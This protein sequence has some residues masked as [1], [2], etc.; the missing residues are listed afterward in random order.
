[1]WTINDFLAHGMVFGWSTHGK[2]ACPYCMKNNEA[3]TLINEGKIFFFTTT[4]ISCQQITCTK[5][6]EG[7]FLLVE[8]KRMLHPLHLSGKEL[9]DVVSEYGDIVLVSN[10]IS[11]SFLVLF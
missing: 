4:D 9:H 8:L 10:P 5:R 6:I 7:F 11:R 3:F 2:L 1:M